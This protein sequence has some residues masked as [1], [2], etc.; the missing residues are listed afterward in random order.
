MIVM[1]DYYWNEYIKYY[2]DKKM[3][4]DTLKYHQKTVSKWLMQSEPSEEVDMMNAR[5]ML[6]SDVYMETVDMENLD[7]V[8]QDVLGE[9]KEKY[10]AL[11]KKVSFSILTMLGKDSSME[12]VYS[13]DYENR[14]I[15]KIENKPAMAE[16]NAGE[17]R[18]IL[19]FFL[20]IE[21]A[22]ALYGEKGYIKGIKEIG[23]I[24]E[25]VKN[26]WKNEILEYYIPEQE[27]SHKI[28]INVRKCLLIDNIVL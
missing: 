3:L 1:N 17:G 8:L 15:L 23:Y 12:G 24:C 26:D 27:F 9:V 14:Q 2:V 4:K 20:N 25:S 18:Y 22:L 13:L 19:S 21:Q 6:S 11:D 10:D 7:H 16:I 28:G 5:E